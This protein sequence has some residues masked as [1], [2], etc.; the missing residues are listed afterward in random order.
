MKKT[1][2]TIY[3]IITIAILIV[4]GGGGSYF[5]NRLLH[6]DSYKGEILDRVQKALNRQVFYEKG[7][8]SFQFGPQFI[9][10]HVSIKEKGG[11]GDFIDA[12]RLTVKLA[13]LPL[14]EKK[15]IFR[16]LDLEKP[17]I[18]VTR[19]KGGVFNF[20]DLLET[21]KAEEISL[22]IRGIRIKKGDIRF[23]DWAILEQGVATRLTATDISI[24]HLGWGEHS[25]FRIS[26]TIAQEGAPGSLTM[27]GSARVAR[28]GRPFTETVLDSTFSLKK[29]DVAH[30]WPY[31]SRYVPFHQILGRLDLESS[32]K[33]KLT[34]FKAAGKAGMSGLRFDY[35]QV[36]HAV[37]TPQ[38]VNF[39]YDMTLKPGDVTVKSINAT[40]DGLNV[41]GSCAIREIGSGDPRITAQAKTSVFDLAHFEPYIPYGIIQ[42]DVANYIEEHIKG[43]IYKL[44]DGRLDGRVSQITHMERGTNYNVLYI[45]GRVQKGLVSYGPNNPTFNGIKGTLEMRGKDF[46]MKGMSGNFGGSPFTLEGKITDYPLTTPAGYPFSA[47]FTPRQAEVAWLLGKLKGSRLGFSGDSTLHLNGAGPTNNY[48]L[49]GDWTLTRAAYNYP[50]LIAKPAGRVNS[51]SFRGNITGEEMKLASLQ[52]NLVPMLLNIGATYRFG[53]S[54]QLRLDIRSNQFQV[55]EVAPFLPRL[56]KYQPAGKLQVALRAESQKQNTADLQW[57]GNILFSNFSFRPSEAIKNVSNLT[58]GVSFSGDTLETS[59]LSGRLGNSTIYGRGRLVGFTNPALSLAFSSPSL[60]PAD[61]GLKAAEKDIRLTRVEGNVSL[62]DNNLQIRS[63][64]TQLNRSVI[65]VKGTVRNLNNP[66]AEL[67]VTSPYLE[68]GDI[69]LAGTLE[70][71]AK[72][73]ARARPLALTAS[74]QADAGKIGAVDFTKL[75]ST[76]IFENNILYLQPLACS[77]WNGEFTGKTRIDFGMGGATRYQLSYNLE[78]ASAEQALLAAGVRNQEITGTLNLQGELTAKGKSAEEFKRSALGS[79]KIRLEKGKLRK[80]A[81][82]SKIF[83]LLNVS[84]LLKF[85]L[86]DMVSGGMPYNR[87]TATLAIKDGVVSSNDLYVSGD[88]LNISAVGKA[89]LVRDELDATIGVKPLQTVD[90]VVSHIPIVGWILTGKNKALITAYFEAKGKLEDP[91]VR[92]IPVKSMAKGVFNI[93]KRVFEL[94]A[95][96]FTDTG[97]VFIGK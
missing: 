11:S 39:N 27:A 43:G 22:Q 9:F 80:F 5:L 79:T 68:L 56:K 65:H 60:D 92:A 94:P 83:S 30:F 76:V 26:A 17:V 81:V 89:D 82:L 48:N 67:D 31:Y 88:A 41:K 73:G 3:L 40:V 38:E 35:P 77:A 58:G 4:L 84:Q 18:T 70:R 2:R 45:N 63:F 95:R 33:G 28:E 61:L 55:N 37:L 57:G 6:L 69:I 44:D 1:Y 21:K 97:E 75:T 86:P 62:Q 96:L 36:F 78:R 42:K 85:Q 64:S 14:L 49:W 87:I 59:L 8:F 46:N 29:I 12:D 23:T 53:D 25:R 20:S 7:T 72:E 34:E 16:E 54:G 24:D 66:S 52:F 71:P 10:T 90:K 19:D 91:K 47:T 50:D 93:F 74:L 51:L 32:F 13:L 15:L